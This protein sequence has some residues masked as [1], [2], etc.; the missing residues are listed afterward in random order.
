MNN[1]NKIRWDRLIELGISVEYVKTL[2]KKNYGYEIKEN[3]LNEIKINMEQ[4]GDINETELLNKIERYSYNKISIFFCR[5]YK[6]DKEEPLFSD[7]SNEVFQ[8]Y[9][10]SDNTINMDNGKYYTG[11]LGECF[12]VLYFNKINNTHVII[13]MAKVIE[14]EVSEENDRGEIEEYTKDSY[15]FVK[16]VIDLNKKV[17][18]MFYNDFIGKTN[19][20]K[21]EITSKKT[22]FRMLFTNVSSKHLLKYN[23]DEILEN[24]FKDYMK[25]IKEKKPKKLISIIET[26]MVNG[27][28]SSLKSIQHDYNHNPKRLEAI[29]NEVN[30]E[31]HTISTIECMVNGN[32]ININNIGEIICQ[33]NFFNEEVVKNVCDEFFNGYELSPYI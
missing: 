4:Y 20:Y 13:K 19:S 22:A 10:K 6:K 26:I 3:N 5:Q 12:K 16:F 17:I 15:D 27:E 24:Y 1:Y 33:T 31:G 23:I 30:N 8:S 11:E 7:L 25:E 29:E 9:F 18:F 32:S 2:I 28:K 21:K 14:L